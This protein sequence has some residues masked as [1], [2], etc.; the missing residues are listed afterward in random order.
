MTA[1]WRISI[2]PQVRSSH[3]YGVVI[4]F[5][6]N[7]SRYNY[8]SVK[9]L[10]YANSVQLSHTLHIQ[11]H[12]K[13][14]IPTKM[15]LCCWQRLTGV[16]SRLLKDSCMH[17]Q[18]CARVQA[19]LTTK[20]SKK[21]NKN[22]IAHMSVCRS[23]CQ[24]ENLQRRMKIWWAVIWLTTLILS[25]N[26]MLSILQNTYAHSCTATAQSH[27][28]YLYTMLRCLALCHLSPKLTVKFSL[29]DL[30]IM[31]H[32]LNL[33]IF[34]SCNLYVCVCVCAYVTAFSASFSHANGK[35]HTNLVVAFTLC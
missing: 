16:Q 25:A 26:V 18:I 4:L 6:H 31:A 8:I 19:Q 24:C 5:T 13:R 22:S 33:K 34:N 20:A 2:T 30:S 28:S 29:C 9:L 11:V 32:Q 35:S 21:N 17:A 14:L 1:A 3:M 23:R 7:N 10:T 12:M 15:I 27:D